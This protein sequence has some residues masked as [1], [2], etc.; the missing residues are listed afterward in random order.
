MYKSVEKFFLYNYIG[1]VPCMYIVTFTA[2]QQR[3]IFR[4]PHFFGLATHWLVGHMNSQ[5][6]NQES[7]PRNLCLIWILK[8]NKLTL[9]GHTGA[10]ECTKGR[11]AARYQRAM[12]D[13]AMT[14]GGPWQTLRDGR[15]RRHWES[16]TSLW[17]VFAGVVA[18]AVAK[19]FYDFWDPMQ[20]WSM[21]PCQPLP[22]HERAMLLENYIEPK[23]GRR[24]NYSANF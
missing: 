16:L 12:T 6:T 5:S 4:T 10:P 1:G 22:L 24:F 17:I 15:G 2:H 14:D 7:R 13:A 19:I 9:V 11:G 23:L 18:V 21:G 20:K 3:N 8:L